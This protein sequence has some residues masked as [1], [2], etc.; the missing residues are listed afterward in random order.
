MFLLRI[1]HNAKCSFKPVVSGRFERLHNRSII[2]I[3]CFIVDY[4]TCKKYGTSYRALP[5]SYPQPR[6]SGRSSLCK[7]VSKKTSTKNSLFSFFMVTVW[8]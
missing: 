2:I 8:L 1:C 6:C 3:S 7:E 5:K 4:A